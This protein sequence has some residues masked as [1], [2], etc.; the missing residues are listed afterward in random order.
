MASI[1]STDTMP[2]SSR[3]TV[4]NTDFKLLILC[5]KAAAVAEGKDL[6]DEPKI[7]PGGA[8]RPYIIA[9]EVLRK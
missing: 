9:P 5:R 7:N 8:A 4:S 2:S 3:S 1:E 6:S